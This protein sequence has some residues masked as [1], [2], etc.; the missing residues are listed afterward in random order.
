MSL[1]KAALL[2][3]RPRRTTKV[4][5]PELG[6]TVHVRA[7]SVAEGTALSKVM[8]GTE[9]NAEICA[10]QLAAYL[11]DEGGNQLLTKDEALQLMD[12]SGAVEILR[13]LKAGNEFNSLNGAAVEKAEGN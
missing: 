10:T 13:I 11:A 2:S 5:V 3:P 7:L 8:D 9:D 12:R 6:G 4:E 1:D